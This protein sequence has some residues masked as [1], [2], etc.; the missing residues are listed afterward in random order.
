MIFNFST[1]FNSR[2]GCILFYLILLFFTSCLF[3][4][5]LTILIV[6]HLFSRQIGN[7]SNTKLTSHSLPS[8]YTLTPIRAF[9]NMLQRIFYVLLQITSMCASS[10]TRSKNSSV[11]Y[12]SIIHLTLAC[13]LTLPTIA[14]SRTIIL[15][16]IAAAAAVVF[17][18]VWWS[19]N[20]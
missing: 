7:S 15:C 1:V 18:H 13:S 3:S 12:S 8:S 20:K 9:I 10:M 4:L 14:V 6:V 19:L 17:L 11:S 5:C 2:C 16:L